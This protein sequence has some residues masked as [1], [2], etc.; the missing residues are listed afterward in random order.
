MSPVVE[1]KRLPK[2][3][4]CLREFSTVAYLAGHRC[5]GLP[6]AQADNDSFRLWLDS[7]GQ[8]LFGP[9]EQ[10]TRNDL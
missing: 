6:H 10:R 5:A 3:P 4:I 1:Y 2:C 8:F 9:H 7:I